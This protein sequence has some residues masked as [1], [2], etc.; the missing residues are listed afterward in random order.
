MMVLL[1]HPRAREITPSN[2][3]ETLQNVL[4]ALDMH[5]ENER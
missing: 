5:G 3:V 4:A 2:I 1:P